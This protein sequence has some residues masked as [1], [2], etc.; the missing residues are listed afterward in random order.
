M[1]PCLQFLFEDTLT[2]II[3]WYNNNNYYYLLMSYIFVIHVVLN[4]SSL[5]FSLSFYN[6]N[7]PAYVKN[8]VRDPHM[9]SHAWPN[10]HLFLRPLSS[11]GQT[12]YHSF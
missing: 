1:F 8:S 5:Y 3:I 10:F 2:P 9:A 7:H 6:T 4:P 12:W 11:R